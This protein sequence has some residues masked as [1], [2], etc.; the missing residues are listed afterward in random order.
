M[1]EWMVAPSA[2]ENNGRRFP[3]S[4]FAETVMNRED[5]RTRCISPDVTPDLSVVF[6]DSQGSAQSKELK[7]IS[8]APAGSSAEKT[9]TGNVIFL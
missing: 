9:S 4:A 3:P 2:G 1:S 5:R 6:K 8:V 7:Q